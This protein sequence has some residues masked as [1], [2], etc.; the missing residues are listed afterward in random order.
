MAVCWL[1][2]KERS[3]PGT[4]APLE[5]ISSE[6]C[7]RS[8]LRSSFAS[9]TVKE[10]PQLNAKASRY[11]VLDG[12][13]RRGCRH[14]HRHHAGSRSCTHR[15]DTKSAATMQ[16]ADKKTVHSGN[17]YRFAYVKG[18]QIAFERGGENVEV[19]GMLSRRD[20]R[21][22]YNRL[23]LSHE[24]QPNQREDTRPGPVARNPRTAGWHRRHATGPS[25]PAS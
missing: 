6:Q 14:A 9:I 20:R 15:I 25:T 3:I 17:L 19:S 10:H 4:T 12:R 11:W 16:L 22:T 7:M 5:W 2:V 24:R 1:V 13:P 21:G 23:Q 18:R 8:S